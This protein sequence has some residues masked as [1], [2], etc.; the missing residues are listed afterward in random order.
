MKLK[1][2]TRQLDSAKN[3]IRLQ[4]S[5]NTRVFQKGDVVYKEGEIGDSIFLVDE[6]NGGESQRELPF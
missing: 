6:N 5:V 1:W 4:T 2:R 3:L